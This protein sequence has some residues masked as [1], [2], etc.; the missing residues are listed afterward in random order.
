LGSGTGYSVLEVLKTF[1]EI[2][3]SKINYTIGKRRA[4]DL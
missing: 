2:L 1:E 4:G 3:N